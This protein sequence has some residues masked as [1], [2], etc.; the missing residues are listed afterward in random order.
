MI[1]FILKL[2]GDE[3]ID[4]GSLWSSF[5]YRRYGSTQANGAIHGEKWMSV[6]SDGMSKM[7]S[8]F[9]II[10]YSYELFNSLREMMSEQ[11]F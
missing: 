6:G 8:L 11:N 4:G 9:S 2:K 7:V 5:F 10:L 3:G 1:S